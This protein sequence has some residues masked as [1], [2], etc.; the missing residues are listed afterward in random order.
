M[1]ENTAQILTDLEMQ[2]LL[3]L[4]DEDEMTCELSEFTFGGSWSLTGPMDALQT[5]RD[6]GAMRS[7]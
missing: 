7:Q 2:G 4:G 3:R 1:A 5:I 6:V